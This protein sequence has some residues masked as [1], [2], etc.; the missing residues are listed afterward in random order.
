M[1]TRLRVQNYKSLKD[2]TLE[3]AQVN[4]LVGPNM[5]GKSNVVDV[6]KFLSDLLHPSGAQQGIWSALNSRGSGEITWKGASTNFVTI[7]LQGHTDS[8]DDTHW[9]YE[10]EIWFPP[11]GSARI[12][13][14]QLKLRR[15]IEE[16]DLIEEKPNTNALW[17]RNF[18]GRELVGVPTG[19]RSVLQSRVSNWDGDFLAAQIENWRFHQFIPP[20]MKSPNQ[21]GVGSSLERNGSNFSAWMM[22]LQTH[23]PERFSRIAQAGCDLLPGFKKLLTTPTQQGTVFLSSRESGLIG[24]INVWQMSDG[25][26]A[27]L[28]FLSLIYSPPEWTGSLYCLEEPENHLYPKV[29]AALVKLLRQVREEATQSN[30]PLS[31]L[32]VTTQ[33]PQL[34]DLFSLD[35]VIWLQKEDGATVAVRPRDKQHLLKLVT[36]KEIGLADIVYSGILSESA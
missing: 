13:R 19:E 22:W 32:I 25:E 2:F 5:A 3:L 31:Q 6:F 14:E 36:D 23:H 29:L 15:G 9:T 7:T 10:L 24:P 16:R 20:L 28:A 1:I 30:I 21:T 35:E 8:E 34:V 33:S 4:V 26:I 18:D 12:R 11:N 17:L 27:L